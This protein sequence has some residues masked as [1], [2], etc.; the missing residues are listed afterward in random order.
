MI[1]IWMLPICR[2]CRVQSPKSSPSP[3]SPTDMAAVMSISGTNTGLTR[4]PA[5]L[6]ATVNKLTVHALY[7]HDK[8]DC[9]N[10]NYYQA[11]LI[12]NKNNQQALETGMADYVTCANLVGA[13]PSML[14]S[15]VRTTAAQ[16]LAIGDADAQVTLAMMKKLVQVMGSLPGQRRLC[17]ISPGFP[18][19]SAQATAAK[20]EILDL[21]ARLDVTVSALDA[22]G[23]YT[24]EMNASQR[25]G[26]SA[27]D[28]MTGT[29]SEY[30][31]TAMKLNEDIMAEF[32]NGTGGTY[33]HNSL[34]PNLEGD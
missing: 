6:Q 34:N 11:D 10:I 18:A 17:L 25:G 32:A 9:P 24:T 30:Q 1:C 33:F 5:K 19:Y 29:H 2:E 26:S 13:I 21:A 14:E 12:E 20:S 8:Y 27:R 7:R 4:D 3:L 31:R 22:R 28:L 23:L 15:V 16:T